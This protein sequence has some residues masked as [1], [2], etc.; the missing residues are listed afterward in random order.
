LEELRR[1][2]CLCQRDGQSFDSSGGGHKIRL[3]NKRKFGSKRE[4]GTTIRKTMKSEQRK[5]PRMSLL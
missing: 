2:E 3:Q 4:G 1:E 5:D